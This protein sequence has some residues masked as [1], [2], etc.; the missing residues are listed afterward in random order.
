MEFVGDAP[1]GIRRGQ[2]LQIRLAFSDEV[3]AV[4]IPKGRVLPANWWQ[5]DIQGE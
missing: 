4:Q 5:L 3:E 1:Q 2:T